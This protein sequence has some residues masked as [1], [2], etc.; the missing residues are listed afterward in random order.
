MRVFKEFNGNNGCVCPVC[1][2]AKNT[3]TILVPVSGTERDGVMEA[4]QVHKKCYDLFIEMNT[5]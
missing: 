3:E 4:R 1:R 5:E 2:T